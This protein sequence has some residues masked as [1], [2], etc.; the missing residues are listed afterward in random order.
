MSRYIVTYDLVGTSESSADYKRL[1]EMIKAQANWGNLQRSVWL[2]ETSKTAA[3]L[4]SE[5]WGAMDAND[6]L[7]VGVVSA[8][9]AWQNAICK[10]SWIQGFFS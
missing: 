8:P 4:H 10:D 6:R 9:A 3:D 1:I 7:Y 5:L 2:V